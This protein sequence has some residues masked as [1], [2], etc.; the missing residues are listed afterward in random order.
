MYKKHLFNKAN[1]FFTFGEHMKLTH[2]VVRSQ[3]IVFVFV[4]FVDRGCFS[5][6]TIHALLQVPR[7]VNNIPCITQVSFE[8]I[9]N[10][11][12]VDKSGLSFLHLEILVLSPANKPRS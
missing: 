8:L 1:L 7:G 6:M 9:E 5:F 11:L 10:A 2:Y 4:V 3:A 12:L